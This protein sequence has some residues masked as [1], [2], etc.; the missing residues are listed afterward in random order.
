MHGYFASFI[1]SGN[2]NGA[3]L[4]NWPAATP[5]GTVQFMRIDVE[6]R[7]E[8]DKTRARY[9]LLDAEYMKK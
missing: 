6:P 8:A 9:L 4:P 3:G 2:P 1:K 7:A 5:A